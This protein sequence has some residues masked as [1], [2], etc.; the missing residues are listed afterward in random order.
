[1]TTAEHKASKGRDAS[2]D[3]AESAFASL[4]AQLELFNT[5]GITHMLQ[6]W[7][8]PLAKV[9]KDLYRIETELCYRQGKKTTEIKRHGKNGSFHTLDYQMARAIF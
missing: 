5:L 2:N 7:H 4:S 1:M 6:Q 3:Y 9:N 8:W